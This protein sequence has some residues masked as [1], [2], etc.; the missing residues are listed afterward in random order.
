MIINI[1]KYI[2]INIFFRISIRNFL[3]KIIQNGVRILKFVYILHLVCEQ[4]WY[5]AWLFADERY[6][7]FIK[8]KISK[9]G[10]GGEHCEKVGIKFDLRT[11]K[12][13]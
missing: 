3:S 2:Y 10:I 4:C 7:R 13:N 12:T 8:Q 1:R 11:I 6:G 5:R 9:C